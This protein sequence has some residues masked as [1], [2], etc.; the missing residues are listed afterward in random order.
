MPSE[1]FLRQRQKEKD[2]GIDPIFWHSRDG[3]HD[4]KTREALSKQW[5]KQSKE[6]DKEH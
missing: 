2:I 6:W 3:S 5:D 4:R 1:K